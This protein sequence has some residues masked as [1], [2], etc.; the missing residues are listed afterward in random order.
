M[1]NSRCNVL[2]LLMALFASMVPA[3]G[4][5]RTGGIK[6]EVKDPTGKGMQA[7]GKLEGVGTG[8]ILNFQ[9]DEHGTYVFE[10]LPYGRYRLEVSREAFATQST[11]MDVQS[12]AT[13]SRTLTMAIG[14]TAYKVDVISATPLQGVDLLL[15]DVAAPVQ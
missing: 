11:L 1:R 5:T 9:T 12:E 4:Q 10:M 13:V 7:E 14:T 3:A 6:I 15:K 8:L 2:M